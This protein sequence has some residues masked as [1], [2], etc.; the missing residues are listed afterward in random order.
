MAKGYQQIDKQNKCAKNIK[1]TYS[2][3]LKM[4]LLIFSNAFEC[5]QFF[6][7]FLKILTNERNVTKFG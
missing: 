4:N 2:F 6:F 1:M 3:S 5:C 7:T